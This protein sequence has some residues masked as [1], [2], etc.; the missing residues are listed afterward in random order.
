MLQFSYDMAIF[1]FTSVI[2]YSISTLLQRV[3]L[4][5]TDSKPIAYSIVFQVLVSLIL[6][7]VGILSGNWQWPDFTSILSNF[8]IMIVL[9][10]AGNVFLFSALKN[11]ELSKFTVLFSVRAF[12]TVLASTLLLNESLTFL[13]FIGSIIIFITIAVINI[14]SQQ[15]K[16]HKSD[17]LAL[18]AGIC[19]GLANTNDR[20][21]LAS[22][23]VYVYTSIGFLLPALLIAIIYPKEISHIKMFLRPQLFKK[24]FLFS[25]FYSIAAITFFIALQLT[26]N[27]SQVA[28]IN[29]TSVILIVILGIVFLKEKTDVLKKL[30][31]VLMTFV[32]LWMINR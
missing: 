23:N 14:Q 17:V 12:I 2:F 31:A 19:F 5:E 7:S 24:M 15:F 13:Q 30:I 29:L 9:Y 28:T 27:S 22:M 20:I 16:L 32:G 4:K 21:L 6:A 26:D 11:V 25:I 10:A 1:I 3:L 18:L 8:L